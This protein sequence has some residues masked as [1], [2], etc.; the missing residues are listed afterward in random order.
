M[1]NKKKPYKIEFFKPVKQYTKQNVR[2]I[3]KR[4]LTWPQ[5]QVKYPRLNPFGDADRDGILNA[6]DCKPFDPLRH[7]PNYPTYEAQKESRIKLRK[8]GYPPEVVNRVSA[9]HRPK[10]QQFIEGK[11]SLRQSFTMEQE[12]AL[13]KIKGDPEKVKEF[14]EKHR[15][16]TPIYKKARES[17]LER[18]K[19]Y[20]EGHKEKLREAAREYGRTHKEEKKAYRQKYYKEH[21]E[22][23]AKHYYSH[24]DEIH[25]QA[26]KFREAH[27]EELKLAARQRRIDDADA[28]HATQKRVR[29][30]KRFA[31]E[32]LEQTTP[33]I[34]AQDLIDQSDDSM[35]NIS[36]QDLIND[37]NNDLNDN[38]IP[39]TAENVDIEPINL[40]DKDE[41]E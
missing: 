41:K 13:K 10:V 26:K 38:Q 3:P 14:F 36:V 20:R 15:T 24:L 28:I 9:W 23:R 6:W 7:G 27:K 4:L 21:P 40:E 37:S 8:A 11:R 18:N 31:K 5:A 22:V 12:D 1:K 19:R 29:E 2:K 32:L 17:S 33:K 16:E 30:R 34:S 39:D 25:A 35:Q